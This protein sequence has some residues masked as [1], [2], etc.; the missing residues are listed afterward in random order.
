MSTSVIPVKGMSCM[1]CVNSIKSVLEKIPGVT[2]VEVSLDQAQAT[3]H[4]EP[5]LSGHNIFR[6]AIEEAGFEVPE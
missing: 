4:H 2:S 1:G 5:S 6:Q 3:I